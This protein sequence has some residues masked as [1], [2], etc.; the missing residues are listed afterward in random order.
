MRPSLRSTPYL[1]LCPALILAMAATAW[2]DPPRSRT[3]EL[4]YGATVRVMPDHAK[5]LELWVPFPQTDPNQTIHQVLIKASVPV[6]LGRESRYGNQ[7]LH[8]KVDRPKPPVSIA[9]TIVATRREN[10]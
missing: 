6:T 8:L 4:T 7:S 1:G 5:S 2:D 3:F 9:M 10:S